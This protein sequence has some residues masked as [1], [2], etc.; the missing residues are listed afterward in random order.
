MFLDIF[1]INKNNYLKKRKNQK[2]ILFC[3]LIVEYIKKA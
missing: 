3:F 2:N 1:L